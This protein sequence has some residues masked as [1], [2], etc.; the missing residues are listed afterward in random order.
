MPSLVCAARKCAHSAAECS[1]RQKLRPVAHM[2]TYTTAATPGRPNRNAAEYGP[3]SANRGQA[4][5]QARIPAESG[6][7]PESPAGCGKKN[8]LRTAKNLAAA[9]NSTNGVPS[10]SCR[11]SCHKLRNVQGQT[12]KTADQLL[13]LM[14]H[15][16]ACAAVKSPN[17]FVDVNSK[18][19]A[20]VL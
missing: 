14:Q 4:G 16:S 12:A 10:C 6:T 3:S 15:S 2:C 20:T 18:S 7:K 17:D 1:M 5:A 9:Q 19:K 8:R 11:L 13:L